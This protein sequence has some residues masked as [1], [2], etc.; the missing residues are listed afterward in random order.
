QQRLAL[1]LAWEALEQARIVPAA[2][3]G[4]D[5]GVFI[6]SITNEYAALSAGAGGAHGYPGSHRA[7]IA[8]RVSYFLGLRGP[9]LTVD[10]GQS[11]S[12]VAVQLAC[13]SLRRG[14]STVALAG[15]VNLNLLAETTAAIGRFGALSADGRCHVFDER[16]NGYVRGE[17]AALVLLKPLAAAIADGDP[18]HCVILGGALNNDGGGQ[19]LT[20]PSERAQREVIAAACA[21]AGVAPSQVQYVELHGTGTPVGD[22]I[23]AAA[24][25]ATLGAGRSADQAVLVGSVKTNIGHLEGAAGIAGLL[26]LALSLA[27]RELP[28]SLHF[29]RPNPAIPLDE[30]GLRLVTG[31]QPW[32]DGERRLIGGVSS[33]GMGGTNCH[34]V[35]AEAPVTEQRSAA[36]APPELPWLLSAKS[37]GALRAQAARVHE[38]LETASPDP[39]AL[40]L[41]L[42][43]SRTVFSHRA[44]LPAGSL[45]GLRNLADGTVDPS[46]VTGT[47]GRDDCVL[48]FPGQGSQWPAMAREL[49]AHSA[50][51]ADRMAACTTALSQFV[52]YSLTDVLLGRPGAADFDRVDVVQPALWAVM[53]ALAGLWQD[54][55]VR[56]AAVIGHSQGEIAA[57]TAIGALSLSDGARVVALRSR[58]IAAVAGAG[59]MLSVAGPADEVLAAV[60]EHAPRSGIAA[61]NGPRSTVVS[62]PNAE[63]AELQ[64]QLT[65]AGYRTKLLP[66]DYASHSSE[67]EQLRGEVLTNLAGIRAVSVPTTFF[68]T[69]VGQ[70]IDTA[71]LT[72]DYWYRSLRNPVRFAAATKA[73]LG[74]GHRVFV[75][76]S[77]HPV[78]VGAIGELAEELEQDAVTLGTLR[79]DEGGLAQWDRALAE[80]WVSGAPVRWDDA[81]PVPPAELVELP[82]YPFQRVRYWAGPL[83][84]ARSTPMSVAEPT[85]NGPAPEQQIAAGRSRR[86]LRALVLAVTAGVLGHADPAAIAADQNFK[87]LGV[88]STAAVELRKRLREATGLPLPTGLLFDHP[89]PAAL[90]E[91]LCALA[92]EQPETG[93]PAEVELVSTDQDDPIVI[94]A[95]GCRYPGGI[96]SPEELW[97]LV[98]RGGDAIGDFPTDRG[99]DLAALFDEGSDRTGTS[100]TRRGGFLAH[101]DRF[102]AGL[103]GISPR[104]AQAMDPQ[105]RVLLEICWQALER[106]GLDPQGLRGSRTGVFIGAM[107]PDYG[108]RLHQPGGSADGHLLTGTALSVV[109]GRVAY[110]F[111]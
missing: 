48:V 73:A 42:A 69:L 68:S 72:A 21:Q 94:V 103:F 38:L 84:G 97:R 66:V 3:R 12:L 101:A 53:T 64:L 4:S 95:M 71:E 77:P 98:A 34:L 30:L 92:T 5:T 51:F 58:A 74:A 104:E 32:P 15:G 52:D 60:R 86:E 107:A 27:H 19:T 80:A 46:V 76:C 62:G 47:A 13:E 37:A 23:E 56:P 20:S 36:A 61:E 83:T 18:V 39:A 26:K 41:S 25:G 99:W 59:G 28:P 10:C 29:D 85:V 63:L 7:I 17:G 102:D 89:T 43:R 50:E 82:T 81:G 100:D 108:P 96:N 44:V 54:R 67:M 49:L 31:N 90:A 40:A 14:E 16:A 110:T 87:D 6:G 22:P 33:F 79:R 2:L 24:L 8:N 70:P 45:T 93:R 109:S 111:G 35:L 1:E 11:S 91:Q 57:A 88:D 55:G 106:A 78:L 9:S 105:Q 65:V 75:E